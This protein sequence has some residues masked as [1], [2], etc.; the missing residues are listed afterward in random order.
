MELKYHADI[1]A[2]PL[3][4]PS[5][6]AERDQRAFRFVHSEL[7]DA[8]NFIVPAKLNPKRTF[9]DYEE[10]CAGYSLSFFSTKEAAIKRFLALAKVAPNIKK[11]IG[12]HVAEGDLKKS[13]GKSTPDSRSGHFD[14]FEAMG[15]TLAG[16]FLIVE[17]L[18]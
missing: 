8:R 7:N 2:I 16:R 17:E 14:L 6:V 10:Q 15:T 5:G 4:P 3:C 12:T 18:P 9:S 11:R 1:S 13:D